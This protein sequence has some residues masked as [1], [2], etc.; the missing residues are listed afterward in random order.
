MTSKRPR[1][2]LDQK[3]K[4]VGLPHWLLNCAA[5]QALPPLAKVIY[6]ECFELNYN[7]ANNGDIKRSERQVAQRHRCTQRTAA[8]MLALLQ[9]HGFIKPNVKGRFHVKTRFATT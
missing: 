6:V 5:W 4:Y 8:K 1:K 7:G 2:R 3:V 9:E